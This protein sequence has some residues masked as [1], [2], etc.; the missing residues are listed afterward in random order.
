MTVT[1][2]APAGTGVAGLTP[3]VL[4]TSGL[5]TMPAL[6]TTVVR[7]ELPF[8]VLAERYLVVLLTC[9]LLAELVRRLGEG[10]ALT[11]P[12]LGP[13]TSEALPPT[14]VETRRLEAGFETGFGGGLFDDGPDAGYAPADAGPGDAPL[15]LEAALEDLPPLADG[16]AD[17]DLDADPFASPLDASPLNAGAQSHGA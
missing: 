5:L 11:G 10:G 6:W 4:T 17:L 12:A 15:A 2:T 16:L 8:I 7:H 13:G 3:E 1:S 9:A 14:R